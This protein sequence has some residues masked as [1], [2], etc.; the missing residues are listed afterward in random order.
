MIE[1]DSNA[2]LEVEGI[3]VVTGNSD[4]AVTVIP[5][6]T[7]TIWRGEIIADGGK[8]I[9]L[10][11]FDNEAEAKQMCTLIQN[12]LRI[13]NVHPHHIDS[14]TWEFDI[15]RG[16]YQPLETYAQKTKVVRLPKFLYPN[17]IAAVHGLAAELPVMDGDFNWRTK[18]LHSS[19]AFRTRLPELYQ[20][21]MNAIIRVD[22]QQVRHVAHTPIQL[23]LIKEI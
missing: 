7:K 6:S 2:R 17:D 8:R 5:N 16:V 19:D 4:N 23:Y 15:P 22:A 12:K 13:S 9:D 1:D 21:M 18:Y 11:V 14:G 3:Q 10:G 20:R